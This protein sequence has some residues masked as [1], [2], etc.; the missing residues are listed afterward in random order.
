MWVHTVLHQLQIHFDE[1]GSMVAWKP[2]IITRGWSPPHGPLCSLTD[3]CHDM[4][5]LLH[6]FTANDDDGA[7][8]DIAVDVMVMGLS[9][10]S[11]M[12]NCSLSRIA[13]K[14]LCSGPSNSCPS[15]YSFFPLNS[16]AKWRHHL[17]GQQTLLLQGHRTFVLNCVFLGTTRLQM[18]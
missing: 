18:L 6:Q 7:S 13:T 10:S 1:I 4:S 11:S 2:V 9:W 3:G 5:C 17:H 12:A 15:R 8:V 14:A 16:E